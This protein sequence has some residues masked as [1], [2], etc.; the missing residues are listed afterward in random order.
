MPPLDSMTR[1]N[2]EAILTYFV[3]SR[4]AFF[5]SDRSLLYTEVGRALP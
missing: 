4:I 1:P 2:K 3:C 5:R